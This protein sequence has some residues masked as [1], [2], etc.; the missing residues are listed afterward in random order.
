VSDLAEIPA[1]YGVGNVYADLGQLFAQTTVARIESGR[2]QPSLPTLARILGAAGFRPTLG[3][4]NTI[5]PS[6]LLALHRDEILK[7]AVAHKITR[8]RVFGSVARGEDRPESDL[9]LLLDFDTDASLLD[10][11]TFVRE[12]E[13]LLGVH[14]DAV[15][16]RAL[17]APRKRFI[18]REAKDL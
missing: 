18:L 9:D 5:R 14:V 11:A 4:A 3:L 15:S 1:R 17:R 10:Q 13:E 2:H 8:V 12:V 16:A 7:K 6:Q